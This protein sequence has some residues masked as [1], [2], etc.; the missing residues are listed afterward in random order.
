M[1]EMNTEIGRLEGLLSK[2]MHPLPSARLAS[3]KSLLFKL[4]NGLF[5]D[6]SRSISCV[7]MLNDSMVE[8]LALVLSSDDWKLA[9]STEADILIT[10]CHLFQK[11]SSTFDGSAYASGG[12]F[13]QALKMLQKVASVKSTGLVEKV[14]DHQDHCVM[15]CL[16][17][18]AVQF[19]KRTFSS[20]SSSF[21]KA[22]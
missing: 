21:Q 15:R 12:D 19:N 18:C 20:S 11:I 9:D 7:K 1:A 22:Y 2:M 3:S 8:A 14:G 13:A 4:E 5:G 16:L 6:I 17:H 10:L